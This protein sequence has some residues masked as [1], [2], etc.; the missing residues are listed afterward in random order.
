[1]IQ[2]DNGVEIRVRFAPSPTGFL[3]IGGARTALFNW[4]FARKN[5]GKFILRIEDTDVER[6][7][8]AYIR[9]ISDSLQWLG[10]DWDEG[11]Y[12]QSERAELYEKTAENLLLSGKAY[13]CFCHLHELRDPCRFL[14]AAER[15]KKI[16]DGEKAAIRFKTPDNL[17]LSYMDM[18]HGKVVFNTSNIED[19]VIVRAN[20]VPTYN[21]TVV[22]DDA[23]L[24]ITHIIRGNDHI[25]NTPKQIL[26]YSALGLALPKFAHIPMVLSPDGSRLSKRHGAA[27]VSEFRKKGVLSETLIFFL[28][29]LGFA[30]S[31]SKVI[32]DL[33]ELIQSF[34]ISR[35]S[36]NSAIFD[37]T[38]LLWLNGRIYR[39]LPFSR[40]ADIISEIL[41]GKIEK[42]ALITKLTIAMGDRVKSAEDVLFYSDFLFERREFTD[43]LFK[44]IKREKVIAIIPLIYSALQGTDF[45][46]PDR[47]EKVLRRCAAA[48]S[49]KFVVIA[50]VIRFAI[51]KKL[52]SFG[53]FDLLNIRGKVR[54]REA[55]S[56]LMEF[57]ENEV[58]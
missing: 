6:S 49:I 24:K 58:F 42:P 47:L 40:K 48:E 26:L 31:E 19:F 52:R 8:K 11:P 35:V 32:T 5:N 22:V 36:K 37:Y 20:G 39:D 21:F 2:H 45:N 12:Y 53:L 41:K 29:T 14:S 38:K 30:T 3:H 55:L 9:Q 1:M 17:L 46:S 7:E 57:A 44:G 16:V 4:L 56:A 15:N 33:S 27:S 51:T 43:I 50:Q 34:D 18:I 10:I 25:P 28:A 13:P 54:T 23:D